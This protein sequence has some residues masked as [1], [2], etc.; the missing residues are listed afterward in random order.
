MI[1]VS[2]P[3]VTATAL[4]TCISRELSRRRAQGA[5][6][7]DIMTLADN[8]AAGLVWNQIDTL[9]QRAEQHAYMGNSVPEFRR[10]GGLR[11]RFARLAARC[12]LFLA[13]VFTRGQQVYNV[14]ALCAIREIGKAVRDLERMYRDSL[15]NVER[16]QK[17]DLAALRNELAVLRQQQPVQLGVL[18]QC[19]AGLRRQETILDQL[20]K[21]NRE[22]DQRSQKHEEAA[23]QQE[24][25]LSGLAHSV[26]QM[27]TTTIIQ[28]ARLRSVLE[29]V[30]RGLAG[31][32][33]TE[34]CDALT[35]EA[36]HDQDAMYVA[37]EDQFR[38]TREEIKS[39]LQVYLPRICE[40]VHGAD[41]LDLGCGRGEWLE[42]MQQ[43]GIPARG[44]D[45]NRVM[46]DECRRRGFE[47]HEGDAL[48]YLRSLPDACLGAVSAFH[49]IE[50]LPWDVMLTLFDETIRVLKPG[51]LAICE[52]PNP[53]N[54]VVGACNFWADPTHRKPLFPLTTQ[55]LVEQ[56]GFV[57]VEIWRLNQDRY[58]KVPFQ[59]LPPDHPLAATLNPLIEVASQR[60]FGAPDFA[61][62]GNK[63]R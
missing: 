28:E 26:A 27:R 19:E 40:A 42:L 4:A 53:E 52:T 8:H 41:V 16:V 17:D 38:G 49:L 60:F 36:D 43:E 25:R 58:G 57:N 1:E 47:I 61:V 7:P 51:G 39:R 24:S 2:H 54:L 50:H 35:C 33:A 10:F 55:F 48:T 20:T 46:V 56:R 37:F 34:R 6:P 9:L 31:A 45:L 22:Y 32:A 3:E 15:T 21:A 62:I 63:V 11:R 14:S 30:R 59:S 5:A 44:V 13:K 12:T 29:E 23:Q 18:R